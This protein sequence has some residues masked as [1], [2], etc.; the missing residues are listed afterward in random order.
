MTY[1]VQ[2]TRWD[3]I[4]RRVSGSV[5][6]GSRVSETLSELFPVLD[7]ERLPGELLLLGGTQIVMGSSLVVA[8]PAVFPTV[9]LNNPVGSANL[10]TITKV[11]LHSDT[12]QRLNLAVT[13]NILAV[14]GTEEIRD[15]RIAPVNGTPVGQPMEETSVLPG[16]I[17]G[18]LRIT[19]DD[20][21][22]LEEENGIAVLP[23]GRMFMISG[24]TANTSLEAGWFW[25]ERPAQESE[26]QF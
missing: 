18:H 24:I 8:A 14:R 2:Q 13:T 12:S 7:V 23:P 15:G 25:R 6:P 3:R 21:L 4:I 19:G 1:E 22:F 20:P 16:A 9:G 5:G 10:I 17:R 26:L 11:Q